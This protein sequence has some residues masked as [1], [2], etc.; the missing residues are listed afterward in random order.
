MARILVVDDEPNVRS[1]LGRVLRDAGHV[2]ECVGTGEAAIESI[3]QCPVDA[4]LLDYRLP[5][6]NGHQVI[7]ALR[8]GYPELGIIMMTG[9]GSIRLAVEAM[10]LGAF[11]YLSKPFDNNEVLVALAKVLAYRHQEVARK[12]DLVKHLCSILRH[13]DNP[14]DAKATVLKTLVALAVLPS[15]SVPLFASSARL[16]CQLMNTG[17]TDTHVSFEPTLSSLDGLIESDTHQWPRPVIVATAR[18]DA[19]RHLS[20]AELADEVGMSAGH[21]GRLVKNHTRLTIPEWKWIPGVQRG[22]PPVVHTTEQMSVIAFRAGY[23]HAEV[24]SRDFKSLL[25]VSVA[26]FRQRMAACVQNHHHTAE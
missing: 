26:D 16:I 9:Y 2:A 19:N 6:I 11:E 25:G 17:R 24:F 20:A 15:T 12:V 22:F 5:G 10:R 23:E 4:V 18:L 3:Q 7:A 13:S 8:R 21:L 1:L 14:R